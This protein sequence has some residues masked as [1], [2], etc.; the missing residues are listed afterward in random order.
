MNNYDKFVDYVYGIVKLDCE[1]LDAIYKDHLINMIGVYGFNALH[2]NNL[3][4]SCGSV[5]GRELY[6]LCSPT[7]NNSRKLHSVL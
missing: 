4:E 2:V 5:N 1:D 7:K 3:I 6:V